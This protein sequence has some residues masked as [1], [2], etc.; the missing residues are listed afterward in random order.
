M[1]ESEVAST[2]HVE[3]P[4]PAAP[5]SQELSLRDI[6]ERA[7]RGE[8]IP[9]D[10]GPED[11]PAVTRDANGRF[12][13]TRAE[14]GGTE[15]QVEADKPAPTAEEPETPAIQP[16]QAWSAADKAVFTSLPREAQEAILRREKDVDRAFQERAP[17]LKDYQAIQEVLAPHAPAWRAQGYSDID[18]IRMWATVAGELKR[19]PEAAIKELARV[20]GVSLGQPTSQDQT[21]QAPARDE[22]LMRRISQ[23]EARFKADEEAQA[24][25]IASNIE[26]FAADPKHPHFDAVR[27]QMGVLMQSGQARDMETAYEMA[28]YANPETRAKVLAERDAAEQ[29]RRAEE[30]KKAAEAARR[31]A[32]SVRGAPPVSNGAAVPTGPNSSVRDDLLAS[33]RSLGVNV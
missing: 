5:E 28:V 31:A 22:A 14:D 25:T 16:P 13:S 1:S 12:A 32:V 9:S 17:Q 3:T 23:L 10:P 30:A 8:E 26:K 20:H 27:V 4:P 7:S 24:A 29:A 19:N 11:K 6:I 15:E 2:P 21:T 18:A 33:M